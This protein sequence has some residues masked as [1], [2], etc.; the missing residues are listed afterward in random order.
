[1]RL[2]TAN[3]NFAGL[4]A[5]SGVLLWLLCAT[6]ACVIL[7][8]VAVR[9]G[10]DGFGALTGSDHDLRP[11]LV[12][13]GVVVVGSALGVRSLFVQRRSSQALER[14]MRELA[15]P[16]PARLLHAAEAA[17]LAGRTT[18]VDSAESFSFVYGALRP[19]VVVSD[20]L[21]EEASDDEL[22]AVLEHEAYHVRNLDP[23]KVLL[24]RALPVTFFYLPVL[25]DVRGRYVAGR[26]LAADRR[27]AQACG[28]A[29]LAG[30]LLKV[31]AAPRWPELRAAAAIGGAD[32][33]D[34]RISQLE[35]G[36]EPP[37]DRISGR[38]ALL[39]ALGLAA[40]T[41]VFVAAVVAYG[42]PA[43][44]QQ[45]TGIDLRP[46]DIL[47]GMLC[48]VPWALGGWIA[49]RWLAGRARRHS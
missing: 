43:A 24:A 44:V 14:R 31:V 23:L 8:L 17:G 41:A 39:S 40:L 9:L 32:L 47:L 3:R 16:L 33:L 49:Y 4:L 11:A 48:V 7:T 36:S 10:D 20:G 26:E 15:L 22:R 5:A 18:L 35:S 27:A 28:R 6:A 19:R 25:R 29:P 12:F 1:V 13:L 38:A 45:A 46:L 37:V 42:G 2:D 34:A 30:A 21:F